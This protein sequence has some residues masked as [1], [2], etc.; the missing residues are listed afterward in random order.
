[1][2]HVLPMLYG[3]D[4]V[5]FCLSWSSFH[6]DGK[7]CPGCQHESFTGPRTRFCPKKIG[8]VPFRGTTFYDHLLRLSRSFT[9]DP[10]LREFLSLLP[11]AGRVSRVG[12]CDAQSV[13]QCQ[14][15]RSRPMGQARRVIPPRPAI[16]QFYDVF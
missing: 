2:Q 8:R 7:A 4:R 10:P 6:L 13:A 15:A 12:W 14:P 5:V 9:A 3:S 1:M 16:L 11:Y